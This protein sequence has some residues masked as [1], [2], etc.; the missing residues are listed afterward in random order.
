[1]VRSRQ[2]LTEG[3]EPNIC[4]RRSGDQPPDDEDDQR[5]QH[6]VKRAI[7]IDATLSLVGNPHGEISTKTV[8]DDQKIQHFIHLSR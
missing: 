2:Q 3:L 7:T 8:S 1:M 4:R 5:I 6:E